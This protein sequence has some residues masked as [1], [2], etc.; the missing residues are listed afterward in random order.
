MPVHSTLHRCLIS[1]WI[2]L[3]CL[4]NDHNMICKATENR[5]PAST[6][7][8]LIHSVPGPFSLHITVLSPLHC[9]FPHMANFFTF[10]KV[11]LSLHQSLTTYDKF[12]FPWILIHSQCHSPFSRS[13]L[14]NIHHLTAYYTVDI[15]WG[16]LLSAS[17][18]PK[19]GILSI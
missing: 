17:P 18:S 3:V 7:L 19:Q 6:P 4:L 8:S 2:E 13:F 11:L 12:D 15:F 5:A 10:F 16:C 9:W 14:Y 1:L